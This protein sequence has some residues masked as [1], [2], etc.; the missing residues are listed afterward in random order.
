MADTPK[1]DAPRIQIDSDWKAEAQ[2]EKERLTK[3]EAEKAQS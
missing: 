1:I 2:K 3:V